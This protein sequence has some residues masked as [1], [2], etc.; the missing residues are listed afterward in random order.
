MKDKRITDITNTF[1]VRVSA[2]SFTYDDLGQKRYDCT[3][4]VLPED[5]LYCNIYSVCTHTV[6][7]ANNDTHNYI[8]S[9]NTYI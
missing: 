8:Y 9:I 7:D 4:T 2:A 3:Q 5:P 6:D 1:C